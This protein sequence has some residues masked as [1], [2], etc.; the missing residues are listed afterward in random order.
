VHIYPLYKH[1]E[2]GAARRSEM[3]NKF[4]VFVVISLWL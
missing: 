3:R 2:Q 4:L 1:P